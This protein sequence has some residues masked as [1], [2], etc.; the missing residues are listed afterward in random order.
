VRMDIAPVPL[1]EVAEHWQA[2]HA[3]RRTVFIP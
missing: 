2:D 1:A 3:G